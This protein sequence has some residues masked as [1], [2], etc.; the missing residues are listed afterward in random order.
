MQERHGSNKSGRWGFG[1]LLYL[2]ITV[3]TFISPDPARGIETGIKGL[4]IMGYINQT[5][6]YAM[7]NHRPDNKDNFN[8]FL[9][10]GLLE[11]R[12]EASPQLVLF[13]SLKL[14][15]DWA[16]AMYS[17]NGEWKAKGF[18][19]SRDKLFIY[20]KFRDFVGE[21]HVTWKPNDLF[22]FR[23]GKQIVQWGETDGFLLM[24]QIN[25][26]DQRRGIGDVKFENTI[27]PI[28]MIRAEYKP[29]IQSAWLQDLNIQFLF[30][31]NAD[32]AKNKAIEAGNDVSGI[33]APY[34]EAIPGKAY[35][36]S[37]QDFRSEPSSWSPQG[38]AFAA[39]ISGVVADAR[40]TLN[41]YYGRSHDIARSGPLGARFSI[42]QW[43]P[44]YLILHPFYEAYYPFFRFVGATF[45]RDIDFLKASALGGVAPVLRFEGLYAFNNTFSSNNNVPLYMRE[46]GNNF[47]TSDEYRW[48]VGFDWKIKVDALNPSAYFFISPQVYQRH[49][50]DYPPAGHVGDPVTAIQYQ[51]TWTTSLLVNTTYFH[52]KLQPSFFWLKDWSSRSQFFK[53]EVSY[54]YDDHWKYTVGAIIVSGEKAP[55]GFQ[56]FNYKDYVYFTT[57]YRF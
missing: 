38:Q 42:F 1:I 55:Q 8:S 20:D 51:D 32:F 22:Y 19:D 4:E 39:R 56:S 21:A 2:S 52:T 17:G 11:T 15:A 3:L 13:N 48:M 7:H 33:W 53:P 47:W 28:W 9:M 54:E 57:S 5:V 25:P 35:L 41:G 30:D 40:V 16:Y 12:Y 14:N 45:T 34:I 50:M 27:I 44:S 24:N 29:P 43:D 23:V 31:P 10:Q 36:G 46:Q 37:Y 49:I 26:V 6:S 18:N